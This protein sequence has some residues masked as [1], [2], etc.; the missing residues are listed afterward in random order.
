MAEIT[1][2]RADRDERLARYPWYRVTWWSP[3]RQA[4]HAD[5]SSR[6]FDE[7]GEAIEC[8][9]GLRGMYREVEVVLGTY[10]RHDATLWKLR[11]VAKWGRKRTPEGKLV[12]G[13]IK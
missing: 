3:V 2:D 12:I 8:A 11:T 5:I 6:S 7:E 1:K 13:R 4:Y 9:S 10:R